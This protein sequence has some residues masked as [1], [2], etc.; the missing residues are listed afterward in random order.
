MDYL[1]VKRILNAMN[2]PQVFNNSITSMFIDVGLII[3]VIAKKPFRIMLFII[4][5]KFGAKPGREMARCR[6]EKSNC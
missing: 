5:F 4:A 3:V 1:I 6:N 2:K